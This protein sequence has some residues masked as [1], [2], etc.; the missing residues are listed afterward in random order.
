MEVNRYVFFVD[1]KY[2]ASGTNAQPTFNLATPITISDPNHSFYAKVLSV[3]VPFSFNTLSSAYNTV[4]FLFTTSGNQ[5][6]NTSGTFTIPPG[7]YSITTLLAA[8]QSV[9]ETE[10]NTAGL[11]PANK[12]QLNFTYNPTTGYATLGFATIPSG[13]TFALTIKWTQADLL[14]PF[15]GF[16]YTANTVLS[17]SGGVTTSINATSPNNVNCSPVTSIMLRSDTITQTYDQ[18]ESLVE[19]FFTPS[20]ILLRVPVN[21]PFNTWILYENDT[22]RVKLKNQTLESFDLYFTSLSYDAITFDNVDWRACLEII[23]VRDYRY[24]E[25]QREAK[26]IEENTRRALEDM[27]LQ[28]SELQDNLERRVKKL[29]TSIS[30]DEYNR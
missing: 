4:P 8:F 25:S 22:F 29:R 26:R 5:T 16:S 20:T 7:N 3:E 14:A 15:F 10:F 18:Q 17:F 6:I 1:S 24:D 23:E 12:P 30:T 2:R 19:G 9:V 11:S 27:S 21:F 28:R 13:L